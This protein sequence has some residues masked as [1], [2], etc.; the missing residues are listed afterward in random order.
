[1]STESTKSPSWA[2]Y[3]VPPIAAGV[4]IVPAFRDMMFKTAE[5]QGNFTARFT[6]QEALREGVRSAPN[7][8]LI[9]GSQ[10]ILQKKVEDHLLGKNH[11]KSLDSSLISSTIVGMTS[12][13]FLAVFNGQTAKQTALESLSRFSPKQA[14]ALSAQETAFIAGL[15][16]ADPVAEV[17]KKHLGDTK[18][19]EYGS[20]FCSGALG[21]LLGHPAN[22]AVT[23]WQNLMVIDHPR[24][25]VWG[26]MRKAKAVGIFSV[27]YKGSKEFL[28]NITGNATQK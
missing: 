24:Q 28:Y 19:V 1:M 4:A 3:T 9:V 8:S 14:V 2:S 20:A 16:I 23:R 26:A 21:S 12:S 17:A 7:V 11:Q 5:Q 15:S 13:P 22:T 10:M 18:A 6:H 25:L 27:G